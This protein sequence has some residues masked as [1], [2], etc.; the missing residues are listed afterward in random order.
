MARIRVAAKQL[1][2]ERGRTRARYRRVV[3]ALAT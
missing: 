2:V 3:K 1:E